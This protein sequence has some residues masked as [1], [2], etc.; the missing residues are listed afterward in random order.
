MQEAFVITALF[1]IGVS[2][3]NFRGSMRKIKQARNRW[4]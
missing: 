4:L 3:V 2:I 1:V